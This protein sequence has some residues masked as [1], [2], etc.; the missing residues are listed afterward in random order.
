[1]LRFDF[2]SEKRRSILESEID[3]II[4]HQKT[5]FDVATE[6]LADSSVSVRNPL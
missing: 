6:L 1:M 4:N 5:G 2:W 3:N